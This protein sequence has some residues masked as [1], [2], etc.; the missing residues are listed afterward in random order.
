MH[1]RASFEHEGAIWNE[2]FYPI[3]HVRAKQP[4]Q[5]LCRFHCDTA[6]L[7]WSHYFCIVF[8]SLDPR[9]FTGY[10]AKGT[11]NSWGLASSKT[12]L[13]KRTVKKRVYGTSGKACCIDIM[14]QA[15]QK[16]A[17]TSNKTSVV[18]LNAR[19]CNRPINVFN[20]WYAFTDDLQYRK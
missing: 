13:S 9:E 18:T 2:F 3:D 8:C 1:H 7:L 15:M 5:H 11:R 19:K 12:R 20:V 4:Q 14:Y 17:I 10:W 16:K 6:D